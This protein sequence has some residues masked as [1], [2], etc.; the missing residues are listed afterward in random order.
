VEGFPQAVPPTS[1]VIDEC[2][3]VADAGTEDWQ[4]QDGAIACFTAGGWRFVAPIE[5]LIVTE[6]SSGEAL[7]WRSGGWEAGIARCKEVRIDGQTVLREGQP[8][9]SDPA[10]GGVIDSE[11]RATLADVLSTLRTHGL[12]G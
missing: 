3:L 8:A 2:Y 6:K 9:I 11:C 4:G 7:Q 1:P 12:I 5:G 10:G